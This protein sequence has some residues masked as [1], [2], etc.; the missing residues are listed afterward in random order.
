MKNSFKDRIS[1]WILESE[2]KKEEELR[3]FVDGKIK[4]AIYGGLKILSFK[5]DQEYD[6]SILPYVERLKNI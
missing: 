6:G 2:Q 4:N 5:L 1:E 3:T